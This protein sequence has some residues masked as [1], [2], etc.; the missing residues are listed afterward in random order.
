MDSAAPSFVS[1]PETGEPIYAYKRSLVGGAHT[2]RLTA[3]AIEWGMGPRMLRIRYDSVRKVRMSFRPMTMQNYRF[4]TEVWSGS[5]PKLQIASTS[6]KSLVEQERLDAAYRG[7]VVELHRRLA[8]AAPQAQYI[9]G[10]PA[11][12]YWPGA[13]IFLGFGLGMI[14]LLGTALVERKI[15]GVAFFGIFLG[16]LVWQMGGFFMRNRPGRYRPEAVPEIML[17][18]PK[19]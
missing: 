13:L 5:G 12:L 6:W 2:F 11:F 9:A 18:K 17:P 19:A 8:A 16:L 10:A 15:E 3:D 14:W 4:I 7:F 1:D